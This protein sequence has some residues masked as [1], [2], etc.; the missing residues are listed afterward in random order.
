MGKLILCTGKVAKTPFFFPN[1]KVK[2][3]SIEE[4]CYYIYNNIYSF[5][6]ELFDE[7]LADFV[8]NEL[9]METLAEKLRVLLKRKASL[10]DMVVTILCSADYY[11]EQEIKQLIAVIDRLERSNPIE[12]KKLEA[13][14]HLGK[15]DYRSAEKAYEE[16]LQNEVESRQPVSWFGNVY[17]NLGIIRMH[18]CTY[19]EG[20]R[21]FLT[22]YEKNRNKESLSAYF[23]CLKFA[24]QQELLEKEMTRFHIT[25]DT[26]HQ[27]DLEIEKTMQEAKQQEDFAALHLAKKK[28]EEGNVEEYYRILEHTMTQWKEEFKNGV[29]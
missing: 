18:T 27:I 7:A 14:F 11:E 6:T 1:L 21:A 3:Y 22:A 15:K 28:K 17:H 13:D 29:I 19:M 4:L 12:C 9:E 16:I 10:K 20:A 25:E 8:E 24:K 5:R 23:V 26:K 2:V